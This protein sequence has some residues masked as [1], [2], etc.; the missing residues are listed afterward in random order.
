MS[1]R[2]RVLDLD[3]LTAEVAR[4]LDDVPAAETTGPS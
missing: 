1:H 3:A 2:T 4:F